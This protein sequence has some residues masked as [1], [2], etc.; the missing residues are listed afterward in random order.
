MCKQVTKVHVLTCV[1]VVASAIT[2]G[3]FTNLARVFARRVFPVIQN[4]NFFVV[5]PSQTCST[6]YKI[7]LQQYSWW[8]SFFHLA[9]CQLE[10]QTSTHPWSRWKEAL[11]H[12]RSS[13]AHKK[14]ITLLQLNNIILI[15]LIIRETHGQSTQPAMPHTKININ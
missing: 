8:N 14:D 9:S 3:T 4:P 6:L 7:E 15:A 13:G 1:R 12:T 5:I 2:N 10:S 11:V